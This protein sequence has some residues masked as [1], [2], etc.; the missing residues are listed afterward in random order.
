MIHV[1]FLIE[2]TSFAFDSRVKREVDT[3]KNLGIEVIVICPVNNRKETAYY[4]KDGVHVYPYYLNA[5]GEDI[6]SHLCEYA[7]GLVCQMVLCAKI[8]RKH[9]FSAIHLSSQSDLLWIVALPYKIMGKKVIYDQHDPIPELFEVRFGHRVPILGHIIRLFE[10]IAI[11]IADHVITINETC[12][13][14]VLKKVKKRPNQVT[15]VRN[16]PRR[17][18]FDIKGIDPD[19]KIRMLG[20]IIVGYL[21]NM[22]PQDNIDII[23][24]LARIVIKERGRTDIAFVLVGSGTDWQRLRD[25]RD[26]LGLTDAVYMPGRLPWTNVLSTIKAADICIQPDLPNVFNH[27]VTMNKLMEYMMLSKPVVAFKL[28]ETKISGGDAIVYCQDATAASLADQVILLADDDGK[29]KALGAAGRR[30]I[31]EK[32]G[33]QHQEKAL[34][35]VYQT[36]F[37][38]RMACGEIE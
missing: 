31:D 3:L 27:K 20:K 8:Y 1:L 22:N 35:S 33:W 37:P 30:R 10:R 16:G 26:T 14:S 15:I 38:K 32:M 7:N 12:R 25:L 34:I 4:K 9:R 24:E 29:R 17:R 5:E 21:G 13:K 36:L 11:T 6:W 2:D 19:S 18:D 28:E 23:I